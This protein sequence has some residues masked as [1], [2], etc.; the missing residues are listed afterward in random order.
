MKK[1]I[2]LLAGLA[3]SA[4]TYAQTEVLAGTMHGKDYGVTY[5]LPKTEIEINVYVTKHTYTPGTFCKYADR[6]LR[7]NDVSAEE[8]EYWT[9]DKVETAVVGVPDKE[10]TYFVK[11]KDKSTA[12]LMELTE[13]GIVRSINLPFSGKRIKKTSPLPLQ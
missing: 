9:L 4:G 7:L 6:Y 11:L 1:Q 5:M 3:L 8:Q 10:N 12:P 2:V 13:D